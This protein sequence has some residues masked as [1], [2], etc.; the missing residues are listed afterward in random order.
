MS[1]LRYEINERRNYVKYIDKVDI[2]LLWRVHI[3]RFLILFLYRKQI[4]RRTQA[5]HFSWAKLVSNFGVIICYY[6]LISVKNAYF[7]LFPKRS[8]KFRMIWNSVSTFKEI[9][10]LIF[11]VFESNLVNNSP[12][13][14]HHIQIH[15]EYLL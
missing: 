12:F 11:R 10:K 1:L 9:I 14:L 7:S 6:S 8:T 15:G 5:M 2:V 13:S 3:G 4:I